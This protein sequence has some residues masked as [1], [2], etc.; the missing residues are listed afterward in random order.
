VLLDP[1]FKS[2]FALLRYIASTAPSNKEEQSQGKMQHKTFDPC[3]LLRPRTSPASSSSSNRILVV[4][5][6]PIE[7]Y[8]MLE[9]VWKA[10]DIRICADGGAN[11]VYDFLRNRSTNGRNGSKEGEVEDVERLVSSFC[12]LLVSL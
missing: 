10:C 4:L 8:N 5:N 2:V 6:A 7:D 3:A 9:R 12:R 1:I 11:R